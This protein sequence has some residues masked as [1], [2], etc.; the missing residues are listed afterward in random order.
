MA[1]LPV[2]KPKEV[3]KA[4]QRAGFFIARQSGSHVRLIHQTESS[5]RVT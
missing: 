1:T 4:L 2:V 5:R 3:I